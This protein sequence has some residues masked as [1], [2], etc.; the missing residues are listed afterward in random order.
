MDSSRIANTYAA[1]GKLRHGKTPVA[2]A[3]ER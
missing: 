2:L 1:D 3:G